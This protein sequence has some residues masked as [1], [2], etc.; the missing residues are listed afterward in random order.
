MKCDRC[1]QCD[2]VASVTK[3]DENGVPETI[4]LGNCE[5]CCHELRF[6]NIQSNISLDIQ[7]VLSEL[8]EQEAAKNTIGTKIVITST[9]IQE[10][11]P[12][13]I[14][15]GLK[16]SQYKKTLMLGCQY[17][18]ESFHDEL[19]PRLKKYHR[20][21]SHLGAAT[22]EASEAFE[23]MSEIREL[24]TQQ[25]E[26]AEMEDF[27]LAAELRKHIQQL[28]EKLAKLNKRAQEK[29]AA[30]NAAKASGEIT[31]VQD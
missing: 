22:L 28:E 14:S 17:C 30:A 20:V 21:T 3:V 26:A 7:E 23:L 5:E 4:N 27:K 1:N 8:I 11:D 16:F 12:E 6:L 25:E 19:E 29:S 9:S 10:F 2:A 31:E 13:C 15:C 18:Y 24:K